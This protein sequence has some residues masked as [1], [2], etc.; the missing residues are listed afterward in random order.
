MHCDDIAISKYK[1]KFLM[2]AWYYLQIQLKKDKINMALLDTDRVL[3][4][5]RTF[6]TSAGFNRFDVALAHSLGPRT[7]KTYLFKSYVQSVTVADCNAQD[8]SE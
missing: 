1:P 4:D 6:D 5:K 7:K 2:N 3:V 8:S